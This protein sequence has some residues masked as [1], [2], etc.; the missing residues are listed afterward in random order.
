M[1]KVILSLALIAGAFTL[2]QAQ[3]TEGKCSKNQPT[4]ILA[5]TGD[6]YKVVEKEAT[7]E[8]V[9]TTID[10]LG[11][12]NT[13]KEI[14]YNEETKQTKLILISK[15]DETEKTVIVDEEGNEVK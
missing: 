4:E 3:Q 6:D 9:Q 8:K 13:I 2:A 7:P 1:K 10:E 11:K 12:E 14:A 15:A 5:T